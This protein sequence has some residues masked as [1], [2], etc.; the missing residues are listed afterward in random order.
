[1][2]R[3]ITGAAIALA[4]LTSAGVAEARPRLA[5]APV[6]PPT[7]E[8]MRGV[9]FGPFPAEY[10]YCGSAGPYTPDSACRRGVSG[11]AVLNCRIETDRVLKQCRIVSATPSGEA[12]G[13]AAARMA[14]VRAI[15]AAP[16]PGAPAT[17]P[18][19]GVLIFVPFTVPPLKGRPPRY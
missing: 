17:E 19:D 13:E 5:P 14:K 10:A 12:F 2:L 15:L 1:M 8:G 18:K 11:H 16:E 3:T 9:T 6:L 7:P 4:L